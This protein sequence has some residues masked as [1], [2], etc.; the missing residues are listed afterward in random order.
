MSLNKK[1]LMDDRFVN[2]LI[3]FFS[4]LDHAFYSK[5]VRKGTFLQE[6]PLFEEKRAFSYIVRLRVFM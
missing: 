2:S 1:R 5:V 4:I 6:K 3:G